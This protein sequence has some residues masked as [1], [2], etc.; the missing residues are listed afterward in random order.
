MMFDIV[1][2][3]LEWMKNG[4]FCCV[5]I[6]APGLLVPLYRWLKSILKGERK[7]DEWRP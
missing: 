1:S 4:P 2:C 3:L 6:I 7:E 5:I